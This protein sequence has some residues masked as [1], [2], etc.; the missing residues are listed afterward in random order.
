MDR[1]FDQENFVR[2]LEKEMIPIVLEAKA[3]NKADIIEDWCHDSPAQKFAIKHRERAKVRVK[4]YLFLTK[5]E[6]EI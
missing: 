6:R 1:T 4:K 3:F 2:F 5:L